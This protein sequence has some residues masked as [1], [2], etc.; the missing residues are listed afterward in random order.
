MVELE[1]LAQNV[2]EITGNHLENFKIGYHA[3]PSMQQLHLHVISNDFDS[4][5]LKTKKH[6]NSFCTD[7]FL[8][9]KGKH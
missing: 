9:V 6:W 8:P 5:C 3:L 2:I 1:L 4:P 7:F